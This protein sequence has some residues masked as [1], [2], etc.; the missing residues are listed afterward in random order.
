VILKQD[1]RIFSF[2]DIELDLLDLGNHIKCK[3][4]IVWNVQRKEGA[5][6]KPLFYD[7]GIEFEDLDEKERQ[8]LEGIV[9]RLV[10]N[11]ENISPAE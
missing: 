1:I 7:I 10:K 3:G 11:A 6:N 8:R 5:N 9:H 2:V 4:K